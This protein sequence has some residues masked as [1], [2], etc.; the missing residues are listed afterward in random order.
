MEVVLVILVL[1]VEMVLFYN[2]K[3]NLIFGYNQHYVM[4]INNCDELRVVLDGLNLCRVVGIVN[5][6]IECD[7]K[8]SDK[9]T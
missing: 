3:S 5:V 6:L 2:Y 1:V 8:Y 7:S 4:G 9:L